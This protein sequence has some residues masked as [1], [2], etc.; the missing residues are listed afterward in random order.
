MPNDAGRRI[1]CIGTN[2]GACRRGQASCAH[3]VWA[4]FGPER[5]YVVIAAESFIGR[6]GEGVTPRRD[7]PGGQMFRGVALPRLRTVG[8]FLM[9]RPG[10]ST[11][12]PGPEQ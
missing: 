9:R 1:P 8:G 5:R 7:P 10:P 4:T 11:G 6:S 3:D 12:C 2:P